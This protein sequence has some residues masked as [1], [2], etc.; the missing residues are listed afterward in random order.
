MLCEMDE[1]D[2]VV[3]LE[4][5]VAKPVGAG[6]QELIVDVANELLVFCSPVGLDCVPNHDPVHLRLLCCRIAS[7]SPAGAEEGSSSSCSCGTARA[8]PNSSRAR[9]TPIPA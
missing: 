3:E 1:A 9:A 8:R 6:P 4:R 5:R 2:T 7:Q